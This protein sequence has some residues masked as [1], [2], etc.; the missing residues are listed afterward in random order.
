MAGQIAAVTGL[1]EARRFYRLQR[2]AGLLDPPCERFH[3]LD[4]Q[5][6]EGAK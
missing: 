6:L 3:E 1:A 2:R 4:T 5:A